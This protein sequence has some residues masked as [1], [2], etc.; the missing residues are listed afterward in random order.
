MF[1][2]KFGLAVWMAVLGYLYIDEDENDDD[3]N[4]DEFN[5]KALDKCL[6]LKPSNCAPW[7]LISLP[8]KLPECWEKIGEFKGWGRFIKIVQNMPKSAGTDSG[9]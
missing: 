8:K 9:S 1:C 5:W 6:P 3:D 2:S 7:D 4:E